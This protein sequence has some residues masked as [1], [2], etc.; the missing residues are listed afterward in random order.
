MFE[1]HE[2][3]LDQVRTKGDKFDKRMM[4]ETKQQIRE[5]YLKMSP[6]WILGTIKRVKFVWPTWQWNC[7]RHAR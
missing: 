2:K 3:F 1:D 4:Y 7:G 5:K 6:C